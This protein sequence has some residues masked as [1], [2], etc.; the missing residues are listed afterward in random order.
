MIGRHF[1]A[2]GLFQGGQRL[3]RL[4]FAR[5]KLH[6]KLGETRAH[7]CIGQCFHGC[8]GLRKELGANSE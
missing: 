7:R 5:E 6:P 2:P 8:R 1:F 3:G 4:L